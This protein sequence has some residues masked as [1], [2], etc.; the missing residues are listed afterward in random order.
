LTEA[1]W[2]E[3]A[4]VAFAP[5]DDAAAFVNMAVRL[6]HDAPARTALGARG[7]RAYDERFALGLTIERLRAA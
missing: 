7:R 5:A 1:V 4:A 2:T 6:S 3:T